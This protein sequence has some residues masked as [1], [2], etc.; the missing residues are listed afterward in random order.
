MCLNLGRVLFFRSLHLLFVHRDASLAGRESAFELV[1]SR[2]RA[3][4]VLL[5][6]SELF[7]PDLS[8]FTLLSGLNGGAVETLG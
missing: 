6:R 2:V 1:D 8:P 5:S 4:E 3:A 7:L